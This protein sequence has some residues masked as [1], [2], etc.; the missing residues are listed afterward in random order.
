MDGFLINID[1]YFFVLLQVFQPA[2][3]DK[4]LPVLYFSYF[5]IIL[6]WKKRILDTGAQKVY[7]V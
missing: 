5:R 3:R 7:Q 4:F 2:F 6:I 1:D